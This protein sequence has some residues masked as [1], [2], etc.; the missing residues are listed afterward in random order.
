[1]TPALALRAA[2]RAAADAADGTLATPWCEGSAR[3]AC[4][5]EA[6]DKAARATQIA[7]DRCASRE[8]HARVRIAGGDVTGGLSELAKGV[9]MVADRV[10]CLKVL[11]ELATEAH[12]DTR[13][14]EAIDKVANA[15]CTDDSGCANNLEWS[16]AAEEARGNQRRA[17]VFY[18][19]AHTRSGE[20]DGPVASIA[21]LASAM[22]LHAEAAEAYAELARRHPTESKW[23][24]SADQE[25]A[26]AVRGDANL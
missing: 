22:G 24:S 21:R 16:A 4:T 17:L 9:D 15:G 12:D 20:Q 19:R 11:V 2:A 3:T 23:N 14:T 25:R 10:Q 7:P 1:M 26:A 18:R 13:T 8:L 6:L 5:R